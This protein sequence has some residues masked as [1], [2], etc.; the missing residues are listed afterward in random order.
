MQ[1]RKSNIFTSH[2][3][4]EKSLVCSESAYYVD[5][6]KLLKKFCI[7]SVI[8]YEQSNQKIA[9]IK[10]HR[11]WVRWMNQLIHRSSLTNQCSGNSLCENALTLWAKWEG[12][13]SSWKL[14]VITCHDFSVVLEHR[15]FIVFLRHETDTLRIMLYSCQN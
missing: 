11:P 3:N 10:V 4:N 2:W 1:K 13:S 5:F 7:S 6:I 12:A 15:G 9:G 8:H 14:F